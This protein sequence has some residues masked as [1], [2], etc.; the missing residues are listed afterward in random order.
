LSGGGN[1][2]HERREGTPQE[3]HVLARRKRAATGLPGTKEVNL[4]PLPGVP[5]ITTPPT[6]RNKEAALGGGVQGQMRRPKG[7]VVK[8]RKRTPWR[9][10]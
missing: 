1:L 9:K 5:N 6:Y 4:P 7:V 8:R 3:K 10:F 2:K